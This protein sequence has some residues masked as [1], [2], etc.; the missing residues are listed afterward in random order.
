MEA[1]PAEEAE[2]HMEALPVVPLV[3]EVLAP[4][5]D[6]EDR[7]PVEPASPSGESALRGFD[8]QG[9]TGEPSPLKPRLSVDRVSFGHVSYSWPA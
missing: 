8:S 6:P 2:M 5:L 9:L 3:E 1:K 7:A 4:S